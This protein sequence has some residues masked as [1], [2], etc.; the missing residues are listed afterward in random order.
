MS[1]DNRDELLKVAEALNELEQRRKYNQFK[2]MFPDTGKNSRD[3][4]KKHTDFIK[5]GATYAERMFS[6]GNQSGKTSTL[7]YEAVAHLTGDYPHWWEGKRFRAPTVGIIGC[8]SWEKIRDGIQAKLLGDFEIG[9]GLI[10]RDTIVGKSAASNTPGAYAILDIKHKTGGTSKLLFKTYESGQQAWESMTVDFVMMD[11]EP[12]LD[13]YCE[14]AMRTLARDGTI[15]IGFTPDSGLT[16]TVLH[17]FRE[18]DFT[19]GA[20]EDKY[21]TMVAWDDVPHLPEARKRALLATIPE[22]LREAKIRGIPFLGAGRVFPFDI[23]QFTFDPFEIDKSWAKSYGLDVGINNTA[24]VW[25]AK[26]PATECLYVY[27]EYL[28]HDTLPPL[29]TTAIAA[30][31]KWISGAVDPFASVA[32]SHTDGKCLIDIYN[33]LGLK[34]YLAERNTKESG[35]DAIKVAFLTGKLKISKSCANL[36]TQ[37]NLY[38]RDKNGKTGSTPDDLIDALRY[39]VTYGVKYALSEYEYTE[40][41]LNES[42]TTNNY[43]RDGVT[44]Y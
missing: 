22:Y 17:F 39:A 9:T 3:K 28:S 37:L 35:I 18:G 1:A 11:E 6:G 31:G 15:A 19:K 38:H 27:D 14:A 4:Y 21:I 2:F 34:L 30:R 5:A 26:D 33:Q 43:D 24:C 32:R 12:P 29:H 23:Y 44:G 13:V 25:T 41:F 16:E 8:N 7:L 42:V 36:I 10:P 40:D 20:K